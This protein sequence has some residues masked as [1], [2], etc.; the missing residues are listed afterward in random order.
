MTYKFV[1]TTVFNKN[2]FISFFKILQGISCLNSTGKS[3]NSN[4][5]YSSSSKSTEDSKHQAEL[6]DF[7][8]PIIKSIMKFEDL[9]RQLS[10]KNL[11]SKIE[12]SLHSPTVVSVDKAQTQS[13]KT[14]KLKKSDFL[15][16]M[17][18]VNSDSANFINECLKILN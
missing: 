9:N 11:F 15:A 8:D 4:L 16:D 12:S 3:S 7:N 14:D 13:G 6:T 10:S 18:S 17:P 1:A 5:D 2:M